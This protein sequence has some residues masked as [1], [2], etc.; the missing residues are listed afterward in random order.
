MTPPAPQTEQTTSATP[1]PELKPA[2]EGSLL[3]QQPA[4]EPGKTPVEGAA[5]EPKTEVEGEK[6]PETEGEKKEEVAAFK[7]EDL[8]LPENFV[9]ADEDKSELTEIVTKTGLKADQLQPL[10][11]L[12]AKITQREIG[13]LQQQQTE[14]WAQMNQQWTNEVKAMPEFEGSKL[15]E[16]MATINSAMTQYGSDEARAGFDLT[17]AGNH[18]AIF[19]FVHSMAKALAEGTQ[20]SGGN[21]AGQ[22][23]VSMAE[24]FYPNQKK[25]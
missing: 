7:I 6:K 14:V 13:K 10:I 23:P 12:Q 25:G 11:D 17:G 16:A 18:P 8:K 3:G 9:V 1:A 5:P 4:P 22:G 15:T 2:A 19:R 24:A 20:A 21:P